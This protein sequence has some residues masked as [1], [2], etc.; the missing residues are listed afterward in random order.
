MC[1]MNLFLYIVII[2]LKSELIVVSE[3]GCAIVFDKNI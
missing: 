3:R 2:S 1:F